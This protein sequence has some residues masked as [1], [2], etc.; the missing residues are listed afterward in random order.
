MFNRELVAAFVSTISMLMVAQL[1]A[2]Q[3]AAYWRVEDG[4]TDMDIN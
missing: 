4:G 3:N 2:A 1:A